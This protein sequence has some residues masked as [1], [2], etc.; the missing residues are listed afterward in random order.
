V[1][2]N[3]SMFYARHA[4]LDLPDLGEHVEVRVV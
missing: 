4:L 1:P 2:K 3:F